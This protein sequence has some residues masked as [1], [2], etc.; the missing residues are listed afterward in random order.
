[1]PRLKEPSNEKA[2]ITPRIRKTKNLVTTT[3]LWGTQVTEEQR[4]Q[5]TTMGTKTD[6]AED[7]PEALVIN[8]ANAT[9]LEAT[10]KKHYAGS[11]FNCC[12]RQKLPTMKGRPCELLVDPK[13]RA[14]AI[15]KHRPVAVHREK[16]TR[17]GLNR[18]T[19]MGPSDPKRWANPPYGARPCT[20]WP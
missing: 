13:A 15:H 9:E 19:D 12:K 8:N 5:N 14:F 2:D 16:D 4:E 10:I 1:M 20:S 7:A 17:K 11:A 18:A 6:D 3:H